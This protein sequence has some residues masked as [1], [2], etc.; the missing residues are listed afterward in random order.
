VFAYLQRTD[1]V[2][3]DVTL[4]S[5]ADR[6]ATLGHNSERAVELH[7]AL[8]RELIGDALRWRRR[9][10]VPPIRGDRLARA[11]G[12][13]PG[14]ELG[15]LLAELTEAAYAGEISGEEQAIRYARGQLR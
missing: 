15:S 11:L 14:P 4:L 9:R 10:P 12:I 5:V 2:G 6:L 8:A 7:L 13:A 3:A 1:P